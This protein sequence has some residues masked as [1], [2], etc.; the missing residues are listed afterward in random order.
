MVHAP[1][2]V[3][4]TEDESGRRQGRGMF[5]TETCEGADPWMGSGPGTGMVKGQG[6]IA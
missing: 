4:C 2:R 6:R 5:C 1:Y 3:M